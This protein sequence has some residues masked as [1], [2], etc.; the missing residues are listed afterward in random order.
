MKSQIRYNLVKPS[1]PYQA[2]RWLATPILSSLSFVILFCCGYHVYDSQNFITVENAYLNPPRQTIKSDRSGKIS[3]LLTSSNMYVKEGQVIA[4]LTPEIFTKKKLN[5]GTSKNDAQKIPIISK[6]SGKILPNSIPVEGLFLKSGDE[7]VAISSCKP[8]IDFLINQNE[9]KE[10]TKGS[11]VSFQIGNDT[12]KG[13]IELIQPYRLGRK[14][15]YLTYTE[16]FTQAN[17]LKQASNTRGIVK[18]EAASEVQF[19]ENIG[20]CNLDIPP[21]EIKILK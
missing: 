14:I 6:T 13:R 7:I 11:K 17:D 10:I 4:Y 5:V 15:N 19:Y 3:K 12:Y 21:F 18:L 20:V 2:Q 16:P 8:M 1:I 9:G